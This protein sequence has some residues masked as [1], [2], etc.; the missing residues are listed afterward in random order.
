MGPT[1][2]TT[3]APRSIA[4]L[5]GTSAEFSACRLCAGHERRSALQKQLLARLHLA[6]QLQ[7]GQVLKLLHGCREEFQ[8]DKVAQQAVARTVSKADNGQ[9]MNMKVAPA[10][11]ML[12]MQVRALTPPCKHV[13][14]SARPPL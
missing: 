13:L 10:E 2:L 7:A 1:C 6:E 3:I 4:L 14:V 11:A 8:R 12:F 5:D 9:M